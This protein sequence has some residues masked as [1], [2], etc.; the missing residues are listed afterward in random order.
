MNPV[1]QA[2]G[3]FLFKGTV[4]EAKP[5]GNGHINRTFL[6]TT[7]SENYVLQALNTSVFKDPEAIFF[8]SDLLHTHLEEHHP[9]SELLIPLIPT[10]HGKNYLMNETGAWRAFPFYQHVTGVET[11]HGAVAGKGCC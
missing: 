8:N 5:F 9:D 1:L 3:H 2:A 7:S 10:K 11:D 6:V 4:I